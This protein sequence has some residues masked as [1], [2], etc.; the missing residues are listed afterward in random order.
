MVI[1]L[2]YPRYGMGAEGLKTSALLHPE[3]Q[4]AC[5]Q[6]F[7]KTWLQTRLP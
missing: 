7:L 6:G 1:M 2:G 4:K 3:C 5:K